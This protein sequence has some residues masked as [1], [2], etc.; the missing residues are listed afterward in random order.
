MV[1]QPILLLV[2][3]SWNE[4]ASTIYQMMMKTKSIFIMCCYRKMMILMR[5][6]LS[7]MGATR[8][9]HLS[10][11][12]IQSSPVVI[13]YPSRSCEYDLVFSVMQLYFDCELDARLHCDLLISPC[14]PYSCLGSLSV[15]SSTVSRTKVI[16]MWTYKSCVSMMLQ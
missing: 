14:S 6:C 12:G 16:L 2:R 1:Y 8:K 4:K 5:K 13:I 7:M 11:A 9:V 10:L 3:P 15:S